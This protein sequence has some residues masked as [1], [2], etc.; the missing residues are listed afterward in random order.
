MAAVVITDG[1]LPRL[2]ICAFRGPRD[3]ISP[4]VPV[5]WCWIGEIIILDDW[6]GWCGRVYSVCAKE[7]R[8]LCSRIRSKRILLSRI[9][10]D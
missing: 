9:Y 8:A 4:V 7:K 2:N 6:I 3:I 5:S 10:A 1:R